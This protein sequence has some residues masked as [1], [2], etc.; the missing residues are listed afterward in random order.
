MPNQLRRDAPVRRTLIDQAPRTSS[1]SPSRRFEDF[2][3]FARPAERQPS[4]TGRGRSSPTDAWSSTW[5]TG[6]PA[7]AIAGIVVEARASSR[8]FG[9]AAGILGTAEQT[10]A[11]ARHLP[12]LDLYEDWCRADSAVESP[13]RPR[14]SSPAPRQPPP[15]RRLDQRAGQHA[16]PIHAL[17]RGREV[18]RVRRRAGRA[19]GPDSGSGVQER[20]ELS[21]AASASARSPS[22]TAFDRV[23]GPRPITWAKTVKDD[24]ARRA[25]LADALPVRIRWR[26]P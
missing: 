18:L 15:S 17:G 21:V 1:T 3:I 4:T 22:S 2:D 12:A 16:G 26:R 9:S 5:P 8:K 11:T 13:R 6:I 24:A 7:A 14:P 23:P 25:A 20:F 10:R 19:R